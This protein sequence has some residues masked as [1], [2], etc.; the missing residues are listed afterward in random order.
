MM[1]SSRKAPRTPPEVNQNRAAMQRDL[2]WLYPERQFADHEKI[3][4]PAICERCHA[5]LE[6]DH[7]RYDEQRYRVLQAA[8]GVTTTLCPGCRRVERRLYEG[9]VTIAHP[10]TAVSKDEVLHIIHN[11][12]ARVR[13]QNPAARVALIED[14]G[15]ELYLLT[16]TQFLAARIGKALQKAHQ[17]ALTLSPLPRERFTRVR[18]VHA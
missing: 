10:W 16:T 6:T 11:E 5:Y 12:E 14:H 7:W 18:W 17:G 3:E 13:Q 8:S 15:D 9:E 1:G 2:T 4:G